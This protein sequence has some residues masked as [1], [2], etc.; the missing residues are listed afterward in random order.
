MRAGEVD[1]LDVVELGAEVQNQAARLVERGGDT[2]ACLPLAVAVDV[3]RP[4]GSHACRFIVEHAHG[5]GVLHVVEPDAHCLIHLLVFQA[6]GSLQV[7]VVSVGVLQTAVAKVDVQRVGGIADVDEVRECG[8]R[9]RDAWGKPKG[10]LLVLA[11]PL[12]IAPIGMEEQRAAR[13]E[14]V[15]GA[16]LVVQALVQQRERQAQ[17]DAGPASGN[18]GEPP[19]DGIHVVR[20]VGL[21]AVVAVGEVKGALGVGDGGEG[22]RVVL[23]QG[24]ERVVAMGALLAEAVGEVERHALLDFVAIGGRYGEAMRAVRVVAEVLVGEEGGGGGLR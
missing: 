3:V 2:V 17:A 18:A 14:R 7:D 19:K 6:L 4:I 12:G 10:V 20:T 8:R 11:A 15:D 24:I 16:A 23:L 22:Q 21:Q 1:T 5:Q 9:C 13:D